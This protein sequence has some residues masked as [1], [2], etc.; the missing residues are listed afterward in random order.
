M[1]KVMPKPTTASFSPT[2]P[3][4]LMTSAGRAWSGLDADFVH[5]PRGMS[6]ATESE[7][8]RL[9]IHF[10]PPVKADCYCDGQRMQRVQKSGDIDIIPA[11][12]D[13]SWKDYADCRTLQLSI[14][15]TVLLEVAEELGKDVAQAQLRPRFQVRDVR[16]EAIGWAVKAALESAAPSDA[17]YIGSLATALAVRLVETASDSSPQYES[18]SEPTLTARQLRV[19]TDYIESNLDQKLQLVELAGVAGVGVTRLKILFR[20]STGLPVHQYVIRRRVEHA[21]VLLTTTTM[22]AAD[23]ATAAGFSHQS[24][25]TSTMRRLLGQTPAAIAHQASDPRPNL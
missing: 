12:V 19:L 17:L 25:M 4:V 11:G 1:S 9:G 5:V 8:H 21:R 16:I 6:H 20:N 18:R 10:G 3:Q 22:T 14:H 7:L 15:P 13:G 23:I 24:H 2:S